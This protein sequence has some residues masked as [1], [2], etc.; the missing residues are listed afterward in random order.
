MNNIPTTAVGMS[1]LGVEVKVGVVGTRNSEQWQGEAAGH[2]HRT[3]PRG[4]IP[5]LL[6]GEKVALPLV[7]LLPL[8]ECLRHQAQD[9]A[10]ASPTIPCVCLKG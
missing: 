5:L 2:G 9:P 6:L 4:L 1:L 10:G 3:H 7:M 8:T